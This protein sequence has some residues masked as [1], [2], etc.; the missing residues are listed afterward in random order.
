MPSEASSYEVPPSADL[1][2]I[3]RLGEDLRRAGEAA[4][5]V[6]ILGT[7]SGESI[8]LTALTLARLL[9]RQA[10]VVV[11]DLSATSPTMSAISVDPAAP[12][13]AELMLGEATFSQVITRD[14][15]SRAHLVSAG[16]PGSDRTLLQSP[17]LT[18]AIDALLRV[19]DHVLLDAGLAADLPAELLSTQARAVVVPDA[20]MA[21]DARSLMCEQLRGVGFTDVTMLSQPV[22]PSD[23][24]DP[25]PRVVVAA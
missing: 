4:R 24:V 7:A 21:A 3:E 25:G 15:L 11:V 5:K 13:L 1:S 17:R 16:R 12:G 20:S 23:A 14:R 6:T 2:E 9:A 18:L 19:Y 8:T 10:R 22:L